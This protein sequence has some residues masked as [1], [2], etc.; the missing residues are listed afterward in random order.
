M[1]W[2]LPPSCFLDALEM[3]RREG[4]NLQKMA[5]V[6]DVTRRG[7]KYLLQKSITKVKRAGVGLREFT[8]AAE[9][10]RGTLVADE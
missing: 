1:E 7:M 8:D 2:P 4:W 10:G 3:A 5:L 9:S 6:F